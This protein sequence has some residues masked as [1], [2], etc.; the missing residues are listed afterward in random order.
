M[1]TTDRAHV[2]A[3]SRALGGSSRETVNHVVSE[4][5]APEAVVRGSAPIGDLT[6]HDAIIRK[7]W[8]PL[9]TAFP[10]LQ[11]NDYILFAGGFDGAEW[12]CASGNLVGT[13][14]NDWLEI[15][16]TGQATWLRYGEFHRMEDGMIVETR[17]LI[18][19]L[20]LLR[21]AGYRFFPSL[22]PETLIPGPATQDGLLL[23][24][25]DEAESERTLRLVEDMIFRGLHSYEEE[26]LEGMRM[27]QYWHEDFMWYGPAGI[28]TTRG[29]NGFQEYHQGPFLDAFPDRRA[30]EGDVRIAEGHYCGWSGWPSLEATHTDDGWLG[31]PATDESVTMRVMDFWRRE[32]DLLAENWVFIDLIDL[33]NQIGVDVFDRVRK[34]EQY[35]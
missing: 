20:D 32:D 6:G 10:D 17:L 1:A 22:A 24:E 3:L 12:V 8:K 30:T 18:D 14:E 5:F 29:I 15:P 16:A 23:E 25:Q 31:L 21:Q 19:F 11:K 27:D 26:G 7:F 9:L 33:L 2:L 28:G 34:D 35:Y 4:Y 13:F